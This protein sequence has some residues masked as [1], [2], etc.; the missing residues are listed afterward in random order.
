MGVSLDTF[1][2]TVDKLGKYITDNFLA[3]DSIKEGDGVTINKAD[4]NVTVNIN[5]EA[6]MKKSDYASEANEGYVKKAD[7]AKMVE[8]LKNA[9]PNMYYGTNQDGEVGVYRLPFSEESQDKGIYQMVL[10]N[11]PVNSPQ[12]VESMVDLQECKVFAQAYKFVTGEQDVIGI[13][14]EFNNANKDSFYYNENTVRFGE[15]MAIKNNH[16]YAST[17]IG[18]LYETEE[19]LK[20]EYITDI[21]IEDKNIDKPQLFRIV[22]SATSFG[23]KGKNLFDNVKTGT[24]SD[25]STWAVSWAEGG[26]VEIELFQESNI[27]RYGSSL[28]PNQCEQ[29]NIL[30]YNNETD[31]YDD[32][33]NIYSISI[34]PGNESLKQL[35]AKDLPKGKYKFS[36]TC[37]RF[38][39]EWV[40]ES[41]NRYLLK[42]N[43]EY[44][45]IVNNELVKITEEINSNIINT[46]G[47]KLEDFN[48][49]II[50]SPFKFISIYDSVYIINS[51]KSNKELIVASN[52][53]STKIAE[54]IDYFK[55]VYEKNT[56]SSIKLAFSID[57]GVIWKGNNFEN[58]S[59]EIP[60][61]PYSELTEEERTKWNTAKETI[62][63]GGIAIEDLE[64]LD[65]NTLDF[66]YIR[67]A[68]VLSVTN[69]GDVC[70]TSKLQWQFDAKGSMQLMDS[71]EIGIEVL[72]DSIKITPKT[73][74]ELI[75]VNITN[76][77]CSG[78][79]NPSQDESLTDEE[80]KT[81][82]SGILS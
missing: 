9:Q 4:G 80:I 71:S 25:F 19:I 65:F 5:T 17:K 47:F 22:S 58:L 29:L 54:H 34:S 12:S 32:V 63:T 26:Y 14:K 37:W 53:F 28:Y 13:L 72:Y 33:T 60:L 7:E 69:A 11:P 6:L 20:D 8:A 46:K 36:G 73:E 51:L 15:D 64:S 3:K 49:D 78:L 35:F 18:D 74:E 48:I 44:F 42:M 40:V 55:S 39:S 70:N 77:T 41:V 24:S 59:I 27:Y 45:S 76:G 52:N 21:I 66:E 2:K 38:D 81:F 79:E 56:N 61:K 50:N 43:G 62:A 82:V 1:K 31:S 68:Y 10:L 23:T 57:N 16:V 67:F 75:K 30:K